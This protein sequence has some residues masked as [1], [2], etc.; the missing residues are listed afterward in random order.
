MSYICYAAFNEDLIE[1]AGSIFKK[2]G[3]DV[4]IQIY[5]PHNPQQLIEKG[6]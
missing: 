2:M 4:D 6:L 3:K 1:L 5:D